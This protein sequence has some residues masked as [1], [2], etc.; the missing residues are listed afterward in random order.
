MTFAAA[1][2]VMTLSQPPGL[3]PGMDY[4][5]IN[6]RNIKIPIKYEKDRKAI[7]QVKLYVAR[8]GENTWYQE[9][10][11]TPDRDSFT[12]IAKED[13]VYWFTMQEED[14]QGRN[15]PADLTRHHTRFESAR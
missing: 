3:T 15:I 2:V 4:Y 5:P 11:A 6:S 1:I 9:A 12:Y 7:R 8:N 10:I 14:I 13:G